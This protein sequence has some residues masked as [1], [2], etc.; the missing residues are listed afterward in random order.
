MKNRTTKFRDAVAV[1]GTMA[2]LGA[3]IATTASPAT[4]ATHQGKGTTSLAKVLTADGNHFDHNWRDFDVLDRAVRTVLKAKP[5]S[6]VAVLADGKVALTAFLPTDRAFRLLVK[7]L[8]GKRP[9]TEAQ[10]FK[11]LVKATDVKTIEAVLLYHVVP[12]ATITYAQAKKASGT[13]LET[14]LGSKIRVHKN[15]SG[16][17]RIQDLDKNDRN[18]KV[19]PTLKNLN[20]GNRQIAHGV[21][22]V[23][24]PIDLP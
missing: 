3:G 19:K 5:N 21:N 11:R 13:K 18:A 20:A 22:R 1:V 6:S 4:A 7:D 17:L 2:V 14:A 24:R 10:T 15:R 9:K 16:Q 23:L 8:T 12:G